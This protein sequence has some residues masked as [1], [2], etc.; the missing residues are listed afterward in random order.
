MA[1]AI[2]YCDVVISDNNY[3]IT[4]KKSAFKSY[5]KFILQYKEHQEKMPEKE[6]HFD[7]TIKY[8]GKIVSAKDGII[9]GVI[10]AIPEVMMETHYHKRTIDQ[11]NTY[12]G[13][14]YFMFWAQNGRK[15]MTGE[16]TPYNDALMEMYAPEIEEENPLIKG[17]KV[18][19]MKKQTEMSTIEFARLVEGAMAWLASMDIPDSVHKEIGIDMKNLWKNWYSWKNAEE[20]I[21][22]QLEPDSMSYAQYKEIHPVCELTGEGGSTFDPIVRM[23][24]VANL[25]DTD[26]YEN[27]WCYI[28]AKQSIHSRQHTQGWDVI[29]EE[30]PHIKGKW[31]AA[32]IKAT[33]RGI[34][35]KKK[36][37]TGEQELG[38]F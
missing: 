3:K 38:L 26:C 28:R 10:F 2:G 24:L 15:P 18:K 4:L 17:E 12:Y 19:R 14:L 1:K 32:Q 23:H 6:F 22:A 11:N 16:T 8:S 25:Q 20:G 37:D 13:I 36:E 27:P 29:L 7:F 5:G 31:M 35:I 21:M 9:E 30:Y 33:N 34:D